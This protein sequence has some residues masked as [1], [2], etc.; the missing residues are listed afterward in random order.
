MSILNKAMLF[1][2]AVGVASTMLFVAPPVAKAQDGMTCDQLWYERNAI[3]A[4]NGYCF[5]TARARAV[6][7]AGCFPPFGQLN[8]WET[9]RVQELQMWEQRNGC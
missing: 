9:Q 1:G 8:G 4:R 3:Y 6:F 7:G 5:Q 2:L